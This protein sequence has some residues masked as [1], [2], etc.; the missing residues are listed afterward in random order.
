MPGASPPPR[1]AQRRMRA[2]P[3]GSPR[4]TAPSRRRWSGADPPVGGEP[5]A[6]S[7]R[8]EP[9][10]QKQSHR[11]DGSR[12]AGDGSHARTCRPRQSPRPSVF[13]RPSSPRDGRGPP[14]RWSAAARRGPAR[15]GSAPGFR[16]RCRARECAVPVPR[17]ANG[18]DD[19]GS[20]DRDHDQI[21]IVGDQRVEPGELRGGPGITA[22]VDLAAESLGEDRRHRA[23]LR[24]RL[25]D[26]QST[27]EGL[28]GSSEVLGGTWIGYERN[29]R[30]G[31]VYYVLA[32]LFVAAAAG[33]LLVTGRDGDRLRGHQPFAAPPPAAAGPPPR[34]R[35][36]PRPAPR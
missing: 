20:G 17:E 22:A 7:Q 28:C 13:H 24:I 8:A 15:T 14:P 32:A 35:A 18:L 29:F 3:R 1:R 25:E 23:I 27:R 5:V 16:V 4:C 19:V 30:L 6:S 34:A 31:L 33:R 10:P 21:G 9:A 12:C 2:C 11:A 36:L 26:N